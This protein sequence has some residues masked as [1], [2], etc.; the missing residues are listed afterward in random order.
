[1]TVEEKVKCFRDQIGK[2]VAVLRAD[3][4]TYAE[5]ENEL[6]LTWANGNNAQRL[7]WGSYKRVLPKTRALSEFSKSGSA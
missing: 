5:A 3:G 7:E 4:L 2:M 1:M 6:K